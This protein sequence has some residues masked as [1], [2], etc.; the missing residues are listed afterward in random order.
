MPG[1]PMQR[2]LLRLSSLLSVQYH[3]WGKNPP[4]SCIRTHTDAV[5]LNFLLAT[6]TGCTPVIIP[7]WP[8]NFIKLSNPWYSQDP[9]LPRVIHHGKGCQNA[10]VPPNTNLEV[11]KKHKFTTL[12]SSN[13]LQFSQQ[14][15]PVL[16][17]V[18]IHHPQQCLKLRQQESAVLDTTQVTTM[19]AFLAR[20]R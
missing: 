4:C 1:L 6:H 19:P 10:Q 9:L 2:R 13:C 11:N 3:R 7:D 12:A 5:Y 18:F 8:T 16:T 15:T 17:C 20:L 14:H